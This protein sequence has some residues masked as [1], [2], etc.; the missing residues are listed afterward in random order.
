V[1]NPNDSTF[2]AALGFWACMAFAFL[3]VLASNLA[4]RAARHL[5]ASHRRRLDRVRALARSQKGTAS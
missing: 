4:R 5:A 1:T 2:G 3:M